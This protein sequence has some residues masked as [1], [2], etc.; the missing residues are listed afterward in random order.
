MSVI[1]IFGATGYSGRN[2]A[3]EA[4]MRGHQ[5]V[6]VARAIAPAADLANVDSRPGSLFDEPFVRGIAAAADV[7]VVALQAHGTGL[8]EYIPTLGRI[9]ADNDVRLGVVG[10]AGNLRVSADGPPVL[11]TPVFPEEWR[12]H[13][14]AH[15]QVITALRALPDE[16]DWFSLAPAPLYSSDNPG[17]RTGNFRVGDDLL[18]AGED[19]S[20]S[21]ISGSDYAIGFLDEIDKPSHRRALF[22]VAY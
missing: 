14:E 3:A 2:I 21:C 7:L 18:L 6:A 10:G 5:V 4:S 1:A 16:V 9:V 22:T 13:G 20:L 12:E 17:E 15:A 11:D 8:A 19:G